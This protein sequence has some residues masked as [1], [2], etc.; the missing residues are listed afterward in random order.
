MGIASSMRD[1]AQDI[2]TSHADRTR[3]VAKVKEEASQ[4]REE[5]RALIEG[6]LASRKELKAELREFSA[7]WRRG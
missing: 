7:A 2:A 1:L 3:S 4:T 5:A 6:F